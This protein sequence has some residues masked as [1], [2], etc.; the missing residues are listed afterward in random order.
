V[1]SRADAVAPGTGLDLATAAAAAPQ[2]VLKRLGSSHSGLSG[3][4]AAGRLERYGP[5]IVGLHRVRALVVA[6]L[7]FV[8]NVA[9]GRPLLEALLFSLAIAVGLTP[10]LF[11]AIVSV[12]LPPV[13]GPWPSGMSW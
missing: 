10:E 6:I 2:E 12:S 4:E 9:L 13:P 7:V 11:P 8:I 1:T 3:T 5:N